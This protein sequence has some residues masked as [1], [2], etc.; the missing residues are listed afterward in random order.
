MKYRAIGIVLMALMFIL[1][2]TSKVVYV[3]QSLYINR[4]YYI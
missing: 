1:N 4:K 3:G 2:N